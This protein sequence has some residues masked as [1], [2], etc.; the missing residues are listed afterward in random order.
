VTRGRFQAVV[1]GSWETSSSVPVLPVIGLVCAAAVIGWLLTFLLVIAVIMAGTVVVI[2]VACW[3]LLRRNDRDAE[4]L[5]DRSA[6]L[7]AEVTAHAVTT[8]AAAPVV[9]HYHLHLPP[10][11]TADMSAWALPLHDAITPEEGQA[12]DRPAADAR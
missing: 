4:L 12:C 11:A 10:G 9:N 8:P 6:A 7:H 1:T 3:L 2:I 5:A